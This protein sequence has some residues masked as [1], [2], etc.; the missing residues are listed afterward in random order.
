MKLR[1]IGQRNHLGVGTLFS[2]FVDAVKAIYGVTALVEEVDFVDSRQVDA[3]ADA[4]ADADVNVWF[5]PDPRVRRFKGTHIV[6][7]M[8]ESEK[9]PASFI[10]FISREIHWVWVASRWGRRI[11]VKNGVPADRIDVVPAG[12]D[13]R[14]FHPYLRDAQDRTG[15]PFRFL[16]VG[17]FEKRKGYSD[18][19]AAFRQ[20][21]GDSRNVEL[22]IKA[23]YFLDGGG[24]KNEL[25]GLVASLGLSNVKLYW[26]DWSRERLFGL[27]NYCD[28]FV[29]PTRAEGWGMPLLEAAAA[30]L[31]LVATYYSGQTEFLEHME[32]SLIPIEFTLERID[33]PDFS[34]F[35][36]SS[37]GDLGRWAQPSIASIAAGMEKVMANYAV[38]RDAARS[39]SLRLREK[40]N[41]DAAANRA[42]DLLCRRQLLRADYRVLG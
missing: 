19:L 39:N 35:W 31:P 9:L 1:F 41:W 11:L 20:A 6:W 30:G 2:H 21:F 23:D 37:N 8:F 3:A 24:R 5:W 16:M 14:Q 32:S 27:Y 38:Y 33:D 42:V 34:R 18:L 13:A 40:F 4:S 26:G 29:F 10:D 25:A 12:V 15:Q 17:K 28:A 7:P 36:P 22:V